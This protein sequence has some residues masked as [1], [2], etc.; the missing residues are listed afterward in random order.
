MA[1]DEVTAEKIKTIAKKNAVELLNKVD[2]PADRRNADF[3]YKKK[4]RTK[5]QSF[6]GYPY[7]HIDGV[8]P[9]NVSSTADGGLVRFTVDIEFHIWGTEETEEQI[10]RF[11]SIVDQITFL[12]TGPEKINLGTDAKMTQPNIIRNV[13]FTGIREKDQP[14]LRQEIEIR[15]EI[16][17]DMY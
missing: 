5:S 12:V 16:H 14:V 1:Y 3:I 2:D 7:I 11:D 8:N 15:T 6:D 4:P 10:D 13:D 17:V 9:I